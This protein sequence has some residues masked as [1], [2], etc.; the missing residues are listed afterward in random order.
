MG[1]AFVLCWSAVCVLA[2]LVVGTMVRLYEETRRFSSL[3]LAPYV[4]FRALW[5]YPFVGA[6]HIWRNATLSQRRRVVLSLRWAI[7]CVRNL[8]IVI[9]CAYRDMKERRC[10]DDRLLE[11]W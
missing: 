2:A 11:V 3:R 1:L 6:R 7:W 10:M 8:P 9:D 4:L 5:A